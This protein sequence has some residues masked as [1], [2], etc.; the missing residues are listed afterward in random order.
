STDDLGPLTYDFEW[1]GST[2][3]Q[4]FGGVP[5]S[6]HRY[7]VPTTYTLIV[8]VKDGSNQTS[9]VS[10]VLH[11]G[12]TTPIQTVGYAVP[13]SQT[14]FTLRL[15]QVSG[16]GQPLKVVF[17]S[18]LDVPLAGDWN[19]DHVHTTGGYVRATS[20]FNLRNTNND[21]TADLSFVFGTPGAGWKP[22]A[23]DWN[24]DGVDTVGLYDPATGTFHLRNSNSAGTDDVTFTFTGASPTWLPIAGDWDGDGIDTVGLYDPATSTFRLRNHNT[25]GPADLIFVFGTPGAGL[26]PIAGDWDGDG[27]DSIGVYDPAS[28][29][30][31]LKNLNA[32]GAA[33]YQFT[34]G[35][36]GAIPVTGDWDGF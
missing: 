32:S 14:R 9:S 27:W 25:T 29:L 18:P 26:V 30:F 28:F 1:T 24:G 13:A 5:T 33:D 4:T 6:S 2:N 7:D 15:Y 16:V 19:G 17:K 23:G 31:S 8:T 35:A 20:T 36:A 10:K 34:F 21:G 3:P 12:G 22:I 11:V